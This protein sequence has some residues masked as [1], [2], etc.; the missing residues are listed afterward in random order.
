MKKSRIWIC[1]ILAVLMAFTLSACAN[2][3]ESSSEPSDSSETPNTS[4]TAGTSEP[5]NTSEATGTPGNET[6]GNILI[7]YFSSEGNIVTDE[8]PRGNVGNG[9]TVTI[10]E[11]IQEHTGGDLFFIEVANKYPANYNDTIDVAMQE[12]RDDARPALATHV[13]SMDNYDVIFLGYPIWWGTLPQPVFT[14]LDEYD[15]SDKTIIPFCTHEG[16]G[17]GRSVDDVENTVPNATLL[18]GFSVRGSSAS[19]A[20][21]DVAEWISG[22]NLTE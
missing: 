18:D 5:P 7:A 14:F 9:N 2:N 11:L 13:E 16:S 6:N 3:S 15:F 1:A 21:D 10:A 8:S 22:L 12:Q 20:G 19:G 17:F 4:E